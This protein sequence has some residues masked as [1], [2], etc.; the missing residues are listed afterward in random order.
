MA[1]PICLRLLAQ[2]AR[3]AAS[4]TFC[5]AGSNR[6]ISTAMMAM[7]TSNSMRVKAFRERMERSSAKWVA[8]DGGHKARRLPTGLGD[9]DQED[10]RARSRQQNSGPGHQRGGPALPFGGRTRK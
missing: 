2:L 9:V 1:I 4:R 7:T 5:T 10:G 8:Q 3:A 6:P